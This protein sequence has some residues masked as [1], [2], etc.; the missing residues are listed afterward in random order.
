MSPGAELLGMGVTE[1]PVEMSM[2]D[3]VSES[4]I[5]ICH[6]VLSPGSCWQSRELCLLL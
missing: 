3:G 6:F 5:W 1:G 2:G 4:G